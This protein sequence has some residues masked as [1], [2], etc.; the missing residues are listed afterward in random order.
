MDRTPG[1]EFYIS[2]QANH[3]V[4]FFPPSRGQHG[5][6]DVHPG[7][8]ELQSAVLWGP[9]PRPLVAPRDV[10]RDGPVPVGGR[11]IGNHRV[12]GISWP[13]TA[14]RISATAVLGQ[15]GFTTAHRGSVK[16]TGTTPFQRHCHQVAARAGG[17]PKAAAIA[18][19][20][21]A[22]DEMGGMA[23]DLVLGQMDYTRAP[24]TGARCRMRIASPR[25]SAFDTDGVFRPSPITATTACCCGTRCPRGSVSLPM[26]RW[27]SPVP[28]P[29][30]VNMP[31]RVAKIH[32]PGRG[33]ATDGTRLFLA[34]YLNH[35]AS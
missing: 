1:T 19:C 18:S 6:A 4:L 26:L 8:A 23:A 21:S 13:I 32:Q 3:R 17:S 11:D 30:G 9:A 12:P 34:D 33:L 5:H 31:S 29:N 35:R 28:A 24:P 14:T 22:L 10:I 7:A 20:A 2:D 25:R 27:A 15:A 16:W